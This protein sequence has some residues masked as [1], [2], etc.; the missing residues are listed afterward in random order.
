MVKTLDNKEVEEAV[1]SPHLFDAPL[2]KDILARV[3]Q[4]QLMK[5]RA[6]THKTKGISDVSG[7]TRKPFR[8][9]GTGRARQGSLRSPQFRGGGIIFGPVVRDH[10]LGLPKKVR[11]LGL[12]VA[13]SAK[14]A[15]GQLLIVDSLEVSGKTQELRQQLAALNIE[16]ALFVSGA[17]V[18]P[19]FARASGNLVGIN[20]LPQIGLNVYDILRHKTLVLS[21]DALP[22]LEERLK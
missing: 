7:T 12:R 2:R 21:K 20:V 8:Q 1:L 3:V 14:H 6:G 13:L 10:S 19:R 5:R 9:K 4:W 22:I 17:P 11:R 18:D 15:S 16:C